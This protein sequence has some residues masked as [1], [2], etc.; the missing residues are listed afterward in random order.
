MSLGCILAFSPGSSLAFLKAAA[1]VGF[2][3]KQLDLLRAACDSTASLVACGR[4]KKAVE[5][6]FLP[7]VS[8]GFPPA[9]SAQQLPRV[10]F[11]PQQKQRREHLNSWFEVE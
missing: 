3:G 10:A 6:N 5:P 2:S 11:F 1:G 7:N 9:V 4:L 8:R